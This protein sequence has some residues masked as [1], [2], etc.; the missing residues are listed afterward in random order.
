MAA[1]SATLFSLVTYWFGVLTSKWELKMRYRAYPYGDFELRF[2]LKARTLISM[3]PE[4]KV[5]SE[6]NNN[7]KNLS[8]QKHNRNLSG[9]IKSSDLDTP[10]VYSLSLYPYYPGTHRI[11]K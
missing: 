9:I 2:L 10:Q 8:S 1:F 4:W 5:R 6:N 7:N 11:R 3:H